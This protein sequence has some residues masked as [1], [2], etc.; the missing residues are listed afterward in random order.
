MF[1]NFFSKTTAARKLI[2]PDYTGYY[3][4]NQ[5]FPDTIQTEAEREAITHDALFPSHAVNMKPEIRNRAAN[6]WVD[7]HNARAQEALKKIK[8]R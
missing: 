4:N 5:L 8:E 1:R 6:S 3:K 7:Y 2:V